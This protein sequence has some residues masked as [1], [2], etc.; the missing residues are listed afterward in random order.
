MLIEGISGHRLDV[1][2]ENRQRVS[3]VAIEFGHHEA[4]EGNSY[5]I[6]VDDEDLDED[7]ELA[8]AF[9]TGSGIKQMHIFPFASNSSESRFEVLEAPTITA[10]TGT[11]LTA[12]NR[13]RNSRRVLL[14][15]VYLLHNHHGII[16][17]VLMSLR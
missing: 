14:G 4:H 7:D 6:A 8:I 9:T 1:T 12:F 16:C 15:I 17:L 2:K 5:H 11:D 10:G 13:N 3:S